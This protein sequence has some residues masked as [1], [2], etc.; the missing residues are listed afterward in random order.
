MLCR[1]KQNKTKQSLFHFFN[2]SG[3]P[4]NHPHHLDLFWVTEVTFVW[5]DIKL[6]LQIS[7]ILLWRLV[8][9]NN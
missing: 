7:Q 8:Y 1:K 5:N 3:S 9:K 6:Y 4:E 2:S